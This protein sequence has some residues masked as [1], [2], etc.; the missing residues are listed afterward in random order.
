M[1]AKSKNMHACP[2][3]VASIFPQIQITFWVTILTN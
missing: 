2:R 1:G 3:F